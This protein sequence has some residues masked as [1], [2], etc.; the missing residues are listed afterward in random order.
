MNGSKT[1]GS[2]AALGLLVA[3]LA[4]CGSSSS[5]GASSTANSA[6]TGSNTSAS[7]S[8]TS[9]SSIS[10]TGIPASKAVA[11]PTVSGNTVKIPLGNGKTITWP[12]GQKLKIAYLTIGSSNDYLVSE[13]TAVTS[14]A[15]KYGATVTTFDGNFDA[16]TQLNQLQSVLTSGK[17]NA[18]IANPVN[19]QLECNPLSQAAAK[20]NILVNIIVGPLC[21]RAA[22]VGARTWVEGTLNFIGG[23]AQPDAYEAY[24]K[25]I[26][27]SLTGTHK[28]SLLVGP[29]DNGP[30]I[31]AV[32]A[33]KAV[34]HDFPHLTLDS[35]SYTDYSS[36]QGYAKTQA[37]V[38]SHP[39]DD[40]YIS[41]YASI[42]V[43]ILQ[44][45][46]QSGK[47]KSVKLYDKGG[48]AFDANQVKAGTIQMALAQFPAANGRLAVDSLVLATQGKPVPRY[49][50]NDGQT[51]TSESPYITSQN[52]GSFVPQYNN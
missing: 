34:L 44:A 33:L 52:V 20:A 4:G 9:A 46:K 29:Q 50:G 42:T 21:D 23:D 38:Q 35:V 30:S 40:V 15:K 16:P 31:N 47:I 8:N 18:I 26:A 49:L 36:A 2:I 41:S 28:I 6:A 32:N 14:E 51:L 10:L 37:L 24:F 27:Q 12:K 22:A 3:S 19:P 43:G 39:D 1:A 25:K 5:G 13:N 11:S 45:L 48:D 17:Y 7:S